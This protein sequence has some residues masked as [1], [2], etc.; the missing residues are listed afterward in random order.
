MS[1][2]ITE[3]ISSTGKDPTFKICSEHNVGIQFKLFHLCVVLFENAGKNIIMDF[4]TWCEG[5]WSSSRP[6]YIHVIGK[7]LQCCC[8]TQYQLI[9]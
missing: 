8:I 9:I 1:G 5:L 6:I 7:Q 2:R 4:H 3:V